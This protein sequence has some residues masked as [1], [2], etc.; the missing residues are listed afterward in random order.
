MPQGYDTPPK[1]AKPAPTSAP[2]AVQQPVRPEKPTYE[3][4]LKP[5]ITIPAAE[6]QRSYGKGT[7]LVT[8]KR[9][10]NQQHVETAIDR[11]NAAAGARIFRY[12]PS[13]HHA[14]IVIE[15][16]KDPGG[17]AAL[18]GDPRATV[19]V[20][21][22]GGGGQGSVQVPPHDVG[23]GTGPMDRAGL[24]EHELGHTIGFS[25][26]YD[27]G[28]PTIGYGGISPEEQQALSAAEGLGWNSGYNDMPGSHRIMTTNEGNVSFA[29]GR[30]AAEQLGFIA[31][32]LELHRIV[33]AKTERGNA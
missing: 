14:D 17:Y 10:I 12:I 32:F 25:H 27:W 31:A 13:F 24:L 20:G 22:F 4:K 6:V 19:A 29:E 1:P 7:V 16:K 23:Y 8:S 3:G 9:A 5:Y 28:S 26:P 21:L 2:R 30:A 11:W 33:K 18:F 15:M